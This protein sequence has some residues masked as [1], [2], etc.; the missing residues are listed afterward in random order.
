MKVQGEI[1][2]RA[3]QYVKPGHFLLYL[4]NGANP[5]IKNVDGK[6]AFMIA[7]EKGLNM[8]IMDLLVS[9]NI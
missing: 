9:K 1:L 5:S 4:D 7:Y 3:S 6:D 8:P 2:E